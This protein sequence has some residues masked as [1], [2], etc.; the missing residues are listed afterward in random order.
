[1]AGNVLAMISKMGSPRE[2]AF[3]QEIAAVRHTGFT[4][5]TAVGISTGGSGGN[6]DKNL[7]PEMR[8]K[9]VRRSSGEG[10]LSTPDRPSRCFSVLSVTYP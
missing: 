6:R 4:L 7:R 9:I 8:V 3:F 5:K 10:Y 1:M 2:S